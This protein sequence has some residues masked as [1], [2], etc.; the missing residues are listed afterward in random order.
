MRKPPPCPLPREKK[1]I[2]SLPGRKA[3]N[4]PSPLGPDKARAEASRCLSVR[5]CEG[6]EVCR[7]LCPEQAITWDPRAGCPVIDLDYCKGCGLCAHFCPKGAITMVLEQ[8]A[9]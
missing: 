7:L 6:C 4:P 5:I 2:V 3:D 8:E 9:D 1:S